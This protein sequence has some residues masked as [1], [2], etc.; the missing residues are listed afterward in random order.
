MEGSEARAADVGLDERQVD[1]VTI[2]S[3][4]GTLG[5][6]TVRLLIDRLRAHLRTAVI[7]D[8]RT[9]HRLPADTGSAVVSM[10]LA[11]RDD[12]EECCIVVR[13]VDRA[14]AFAAR[15]PV[16]TFTSIGDALQARA[17]AQCGYGDGWAAD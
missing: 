4:P 14:E 17:L 3:T 1:G 9:V 8:L 13:G 5:E 10:L 16:A 6:R 12:P 7:V 15:S 11:G 2:V